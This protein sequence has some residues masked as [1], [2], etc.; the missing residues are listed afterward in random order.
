MPGGEIWWSGAE[1]GGYA[2]DGPCPC[3]VV[4]PVLYF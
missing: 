1:V 4:A 2:D 3:D